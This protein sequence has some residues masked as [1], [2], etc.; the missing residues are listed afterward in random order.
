MR[1]IGNGTCSFLLE[2]HEVMWTQLKNCP[3]LC[4][5]LRERDLS[6]YGSEIRNWNGFNRLGGAVVT[7]FVSFGLE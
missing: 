1:S 3:I 7:F 6:P 2:Y 5:N 4:F